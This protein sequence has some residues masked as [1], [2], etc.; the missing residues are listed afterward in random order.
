MAS[1]LTLKSPGGSLIGGPGDL[2][3][4][5]SKGRQESK[6]KETCNAVCGEIN[7]RSCSWFPHAP[8]S[9]QKGDLRLSGPPSEQGAGSGAQTRDRVPADA[10]DATTP[11][12]SRLSK[13]MFRQYGSFKM[14]KMRCRN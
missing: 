6:G 10:T 7:L 2:P 4:C 8:S 12:G 1:K 3:S 14:L 11:L 9:P 5:E 13:C